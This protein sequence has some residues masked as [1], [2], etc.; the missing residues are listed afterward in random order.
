ML[1]NTEPET[2]KLE[3]SS[4]LSSLRRRTCEFDYEVARVYINRTSQNTTFL[5]IVGSITIIS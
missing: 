5:A 4:T 2:L 1:L 3:T